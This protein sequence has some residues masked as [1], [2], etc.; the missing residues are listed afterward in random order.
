MFSI[1]FYIIQHL[2]I[3][4]QRFFWPEGKTGTLGPL[5]PD[6][7]T[8]TVCSEL[9][10]DKA[11]LLGAHSGRYD[12]ECTTVAWAF[13]KCMYAFEDQRKDGWIEACG[14]WVFR[15]IPKLD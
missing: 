10:L 7:M 12:R 1:L 14:Q 9:G 2:F 5:G 13:S 3:V 15:V 8:M 4:E 6:E 11:S